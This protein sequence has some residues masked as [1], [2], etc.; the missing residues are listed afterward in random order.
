MMAV[1][2][3]IALIVLMLGTMLSTASHAA[4]FVPRTILTL[5]DSGDGDQLPF[6]D[7]HRKAEM[8]LNHLG[9]VLDYRDIKKGLPSDEDIKNSHGILTWFPSG[10]RMKDPEAYLE[11]A[12]HA[13]DLGKKFVVLG[14]IG[15][16]EDKSG[17]PVSKE[18]LNAF[19]HKFGLE[20][21]TSWEGLTYNVSVAFI[22]KK[23]MNFERPVSGVLHPYWQMR[24]VS[25]KVRPI[26]VLRKN[27][28]PESDSVIAAF[29]PQGA[30]VAE[31]YAVFDAMEDAKTVDD[32]KIYRRQWYMNPFLFFRTAFDTDA[33]PKPDTTTIDGRRIFYSHIDGDGWN[34]MSNVPEYKSTFTL[35]SEVVLNEIVKKFSDLPITIAPIGAEL[36]KNWVGSDTSQEIA[37]KLFSQ[38]N[39]E[40]ASH[41]YSH[42]YLWSFFRKY[43]NEQ[44]RKYLGNYAYGTWDDFSMASLVGIKKSVYKGPEATCNRDESPFIKENI[45]PYDVPRAYANMRFNLAEEIKGSVD[46]INQFVPEG[47]KIK[48]IQW[49]GDTL[50]FECAIYQARKNG[51][52]NINGGDSRLDNEFPSYAWV[53]PV[54]RQVGQEIQIYASNS[55]ENTYTLNWTDRYYGFQF[56]INTSKNTESPIRLKPFNVYYHMFSGEKL[57]SLNALRRNMQYARDN[58]SELHPIH[59]S[60]YA[61]IANGFYSTKFVSKGDKR[62]EVQ[63][64]GALQTIRFDRSVLETVDYEQSKGVIGHSHFQG[65]LYVFL[66]QKAD[67]PIIAIK[68]NSEWGKPATASIPYLTSSNWEIWNVGTGV[69]LEFSAMG[70]GAG[71]MKWKMPTPGKYSVQ[72]VEKDGA[73]PKTLLDAATDSEGLLNVTLN[74]NGATPARF[75]IKRND[76]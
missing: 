30:Y 28:D 53:A 67:K 51:L 31:R 50:P 52:L 27:D 5:Y 12:S 71:N 62:W 36:D 6:S 55:N 58:I 13:M 21:D 65:A 32:T 74:V 20:T 14:D 11:W 16:N 75:I 61:E 15:A 40:A 57:A 66:D 35:A 38:P 18:K 26:L 29:T 43:D 25:N 42:P 39:V 34:N 64:R 76:V 8:P 7:L 47:K 46:F 33:L 19:L 70:F 10:I 9:L 22:D 73:A 60:R 24:M 72:A 69:A 23:I 49:S 4:P 2:R 17:K 59:T 54:G 45:N 48:L 63:D 41:T 37:R 68:K 1:Y 44:E 56:L 3:I